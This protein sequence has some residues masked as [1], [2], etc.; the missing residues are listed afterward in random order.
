MTSTAIQRLLIATGNQGKIAELRDLLRPLGLPL[1]TL[2]DLPTI[3]EPAE[4]GST[5]ADNAAL[6][7]A[8]YA[9]ASGEW[10][11]ADDSGL[12]IDF[13]DGAPGIYSARFGGKG[14]SYKNRMRIVLSDLADVRDEQ[15][16]A[17]FVCVITVADPTGGIAISAEGV[18]E[19]MIAHEARGSNGFGYDP[20]FIPAGYE[21]TFGELTDDQKRS[22]SHRGKA[23]ADL[24]RKMLDFT[25]V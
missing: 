11:I 7:A 17:R 22:I 6:K 16:T 14:L 19:G 3:A 20:I 4:T 18:C 10:A 1:I 23:S 8:F 2:A 25:G 12:E 24:I 5:F 13:L 9:H 15:R 21:F